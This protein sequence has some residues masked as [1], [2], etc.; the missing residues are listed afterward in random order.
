VGGQGKFYT[1][2]GGKTPG[3]DVEKKEDSKDVDTQGSKE[4]L[5]KNK[6]REEEMDLDLRE[7]EGKGN[8]VEGGAEDSY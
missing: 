7:G 3:G 5:S 6:W 8:S 4:K 2:V 1:L